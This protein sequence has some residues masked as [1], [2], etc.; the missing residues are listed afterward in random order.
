[1]ANEKKWVN[2]ENALGITTQERLGMN[3]HDYYQMVVNFLGYDKVKNCVPFTLTEIKEA[4]PKDEHL[5]N[6]PMRKWDWASGFNVWTTKY[7]EVVRPTN[8]PLRSVMKAKGINCYSNA[9][10]V[11][12]LKECARMMIEEVL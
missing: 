10:G 8:S 4:F 9:E 12:I 7:E 1:M 2:V 11:C 6:L 3:H 5:N